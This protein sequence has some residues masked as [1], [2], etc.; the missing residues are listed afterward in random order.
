MI[1]KKKLHFDGIPGSY[2]GEKSLV[3][4][5]TCPSVREYVEDTL[6]GVLPFDPSLEVE[7]PD[8]SP[9]LD[10][11]SIKA[12][13]AMADKVER[14]DLV[15]QL[16]QLVSDLEKDVSQSSQPGAEPAAAEPQPSAESAPAE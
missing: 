6:N 7:N 8:A 16:D 12:Q 9:D 11:D 10:E 14:V 3:T 4:P 15:R 13:F 1:H 5:P 2:P